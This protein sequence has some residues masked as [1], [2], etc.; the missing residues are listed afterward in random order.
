M[1]LADT[2]GSKGL[3]QAVQRT[4]ASRFARDTFTV[5]GG[6]LPSLTVELESYGNF[7]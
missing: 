2:G 4:G 6:W 7:K 5:I 3:N 1:P